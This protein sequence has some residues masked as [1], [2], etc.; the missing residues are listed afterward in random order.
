MRKW[1][2]LLGVVVIVVCASR[3]A[4]AEEEDLNGRAEW[5]QGQ[6]AYPRIAIPEN[7]MRGYARCP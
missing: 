2:G 3:S 4:H 1:S 6:R 7:A 5:W